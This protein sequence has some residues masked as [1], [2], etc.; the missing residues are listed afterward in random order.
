MSGLGLLAAIVII[1]GPSDLSFVDSVSGASRTLPLPGPG[2]ALFVAPDGR[3]VV[4]AAAEDA[5]WL[6]GEGRPVERWPGRLVPLFFDEIDRAWALLPDELVLITYPER[7]PLR[8]HRVEGLVGVRQ[9]GCS[10]D[11]RLVAVV[12]GDRPEPAMWMVVPDDPQAVRPVPLPAA[13]KL[14]AVAPDA[15]MVAVGL[16]GGRVLLV[17]PEAPAL[18]VLVETPGEASA[19]RFEARGGTLLVGCHNGTGGALLGVRAEI[20]PGK[21]VKEQFRTPLPFPPSVLV[22]A[23]SEVLALCGDRVEV[24]GKGGRKLIR[25]LDAPGARGMVLAVAE[26][27]SAL[28]EWSDR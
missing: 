27:R 16:A 25:E 26:A 22:A 21:P 15:S 24:L 7:L 17:A 12:P 6:V 5:T 2:A 14:I 1:L 10:G 11:G 18:P 8:R 13:G 19:L 20:R 3:V 23:G 4:P 9:A 28:P